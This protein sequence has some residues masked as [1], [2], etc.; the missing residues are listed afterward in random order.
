MKNRIR[1]TFW[2]KL[3]PRLDSSCATWISCRVGLLILA[4]TICSSGAVSRAASAA[5]DLPAFDRREVGPELRVRK[6]DG[7][8]NYTR[9]L[10]GATA[11]TRKTPLTLGETLEFDAR[12]YQLQSSL[13]VRIVTLWTGEVLPASCSLSERRSGTSSRFSAKLFGDSR[14]PEVGL[15]VSDVATILQPVG[16]WDVCPAD[17]RVRPAGVWRE[18][19][20]GIGE[21]DNVVVPDYVDELTRKFWNRRAIQLP[22]PAKAPAG[23]GCLVVLSGQW[24]EGVPSVRSLSSRDEIR[25]GGTLKFVFVDERGVRRRI[26]VSGRGGK[27][28]IVFPDDRVKSATVGIQ[29]LQIRLHMDREL[30]LS[31][32]GVI[33]AKVQK[34][35]G[36]LVAIEVEGP[37]VPSF[38]DEPDRPHALFVHEPFIRRT[39]RESNQ[40][41]N[42]RT[43]IE[44]SVRKTADSDRVLLNS[45]D[46]IYGL[47][48]E[49]ATGVSVVPRSKGHRLLIDRKEI[50]AVCFGRPKAAARMPVTGEFAQIDLVPD[51]SCSLGGTEEAFW[52]RSAIR[53]ATDDGLVMQHPLL[54]DVTVRWKM[55]RRITPLFAGSYRLL[56]PGPRHLGNGYRESFSR[57]QPDGTELNFN[58]KVTAQELAQPVFL[59]ADIAEL[60]PSALDTL[61]ATPFLDEV[62]AGFLATQVFLNREFAGTLNELINVRSPATEPERVRL[63][64][65]AR[66]LKAGENKVEIRQTSAKDDTTSFDDFEIR[67]I[68][69]E[70]ERTVDFEA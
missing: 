38:D 32:N 40:S 13:P 10:G 52:I 60:I 41:S 56:D 51:A 49:A 25:S 68:A 50:A 37:L 12:P 6:S 59:S 45:G 24:P 65:P 67:A 31:S 62:R 1:G 7:T 44:N 23:N 30:T 28:R 26:E 42:I 69:I 58:F 4:A 34:P 55:I 61:K 11:L 63:G 66:L 15:R 43:G 9:F 20:I 22:R 36:D 57:V 53:Q 2:P 27:R 8:T 70:V 14:L 3:L 35:I 47:I 64:L 5:D 46:E 19:E 21:N 29:R 17:S 54:G 16:T 18:V 39:N 48:S 33:L